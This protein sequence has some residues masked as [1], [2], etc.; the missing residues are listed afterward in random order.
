MIVGSREMTAIG[1][2]GLV[3]TATRL[4]ERVSLLQPSY[5]EQIEA[6]IATLQAKLADVTKNPEN[7]VI[8][9][10]DTQNKVNCVIVA[11]SKFLSTFFSIGS[12]CFSDLEI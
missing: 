2:G 6:R 5:L 3:E 10:A 11:L 8:A 12:S 1:V 9:D 7:A 4:S